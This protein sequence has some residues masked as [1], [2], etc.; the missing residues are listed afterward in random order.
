MAISAA[1]FFGGPDR[2]C[3]GKSGDDIEL[4]KSLSP[5]N[6]R[7]GSGGWNGDRYPGKSVLLALLGGA[8]WKRRPRVVAQPIT[9]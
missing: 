6:C 9:Q 8:E 5:V 1:E 2:Q 4:S 7:I 3:G